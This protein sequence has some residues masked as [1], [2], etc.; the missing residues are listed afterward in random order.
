METTFLIMQAIFALGV[1]LV[2]YKAFE[3]S[4]L[5]MFMAAVLLA[6][7][8]ASVAFADKDSSILYGFLKGLYGVKDDHVQ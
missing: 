2:F 6:C 5:H 4:K 8:W 7:M 3:G 1:G